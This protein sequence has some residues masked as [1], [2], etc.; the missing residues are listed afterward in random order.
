MSMENNELMNNAVD[1]VVEEMVETGNKAGFDAFGLMKDCVILW[2]SVKAV[3]I[4]IDL[5]MKGFKRGK[6]WLTKRAENKKS[7]KE[8]PEDVN[9]EG[10]DFENDC[11]VE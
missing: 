4:A 11:K 3:D 2:A 8:I 5:S 9:V 6:A 10:L 7:K 1:T